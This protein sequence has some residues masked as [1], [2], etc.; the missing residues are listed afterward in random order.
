[1]PY[2]NRD[3]KR[4]HNFDNYPY[5][6]DGHARRPSCVEFVVRG[7]SRRQNSGTVEWVAGS[8][9]ARNF[10]GKALHGFD[11]TAKL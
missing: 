6:M 7:G 10:E 11:E 2:Y 8:E 9:R 5:S 4:D 1:M 3:P